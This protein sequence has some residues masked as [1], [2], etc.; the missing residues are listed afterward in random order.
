[1]LLQE[2]MKKDQHFLKRYGRKKFIE[3]RSGAAA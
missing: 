2:K 1:M 3:A